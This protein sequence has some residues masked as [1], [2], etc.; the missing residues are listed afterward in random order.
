M[1]LRGFCTTLFYNGYPFGETIGTDKSLEITGEMID[2]N[3]S[4]IIF[5]EAE[6]TRTGNMNPFKPGI[7]FLALNMKVPIIP[8]KVEGLYEI[9]PAETLFPKLGKSKVKI[10]KPILAKEFEKL[11]YISATKLIEKR[12]RGL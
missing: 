2:R 6:R 7:G 11:S 3:Y 10:G 9:M 8:I 4:I 12:I 1:R 5:P